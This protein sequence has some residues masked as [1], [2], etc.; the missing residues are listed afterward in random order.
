MAEVQVCA[1]H[2]DEG[3]RPEPV[4]DEVGSVQYT[5][6]R[7]KGHPTEG[8]Y[9]WLHV[10][11]PPGLN[12]VSGLAAEL[13]L[14]VELPNV[15][16]QYRGFWVEYG[17]VEQRYAERNPQDFAMLVE[18]YGHAAIHGKTYTVTVFLVHT[19][20]NLSQH[21]SVLMHPGPSTGRWNY[22]SPVSW[23]S[24]PP[25]S[26]AESAPAWSTEMSWEA[27]GCS[28]AYVPGQTEV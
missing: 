5:C 22:V 13:G 10:P 6:T 24:L 3:V 17:V 28:V 12:D 1:F 8:P 27:L 20:G 9:T 19:L 16:A 7:T 18:R 25:R 11:T 4:H 15:L 23:W 14:H 2:G 26:E 21:G